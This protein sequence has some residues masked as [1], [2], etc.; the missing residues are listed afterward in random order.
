MSKLLTRD[1]IHDL[2]T[3]REDRLPGY[4]IHDAEHVEHPEHVGSQL[5]TGANLLQLARLLQNVHR[6][7]GARETERRRKTADAGTD[8][9]ERQVAS[10][11]VSYPGVCRESRRTPGGS[12]P[13]HP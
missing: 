1:R 7:A 10:A 5:D 3:V 9:Q 6:E 8:D 12:P 13:G 2:V 4:R 11:H